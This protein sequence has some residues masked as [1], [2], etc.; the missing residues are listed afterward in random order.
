MT[1]QHW[2]STAVRAGR[3]NRSVWDFM[4]APEPWMASG[5]CAQTDPDAWYVEKGGNVNPAKRVCL[6]C[7][8]QAECLACALEHDEH[9]GVWGG[10]SERER[11]KLKRATA[12]PTGTALEDCA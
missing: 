12:V 6:A 2:S 5:L 4:P 3:D 10:K 9:F 7:P 11:R 1:A 8:V